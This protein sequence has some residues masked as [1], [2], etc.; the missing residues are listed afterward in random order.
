MPVNLKAKKQ[1]V[2]RMYKV[3]VNR[4]R[5]TLT[6]LMMWLMQSQEKTLEVCLR[7]IRLKLKILLERQ[8]EEQ[9]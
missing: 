2:A 1:L 8:E 4:V 9:K 6:I 7:Q 3:G 5:L